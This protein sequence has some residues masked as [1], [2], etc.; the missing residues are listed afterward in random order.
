MGLIELKPCQGR[1]S[2]GHC[3]R[4]PFTSSI[5][6]MNFRFGIFGLQIPHM[7]CEFFA[8]LKPLLGHVSMQK[9]DSGDQLQALHP[10]DHRKRPAPFRWLPGCSG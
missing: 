9:R 2:S 8:V 5:A 3:A 4:K 7:L 6:P 1:M 10:I